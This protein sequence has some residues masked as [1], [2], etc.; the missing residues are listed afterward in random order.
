MLQK[1]LQQSQDL[2]FKN[3]FLIK[4]PKKHL[5]SAPKIE[6]I[7][8]QSNKLKEN[9]SI[10]NIYIELTNL[11]RKI[12]GQTGKLIFAQQSVDSFKIVKGDIIGIKTTLRKLNLNNFLEKIIFIV[13]VGEAAN[14]LPQGRGFFHPQG[15]IQ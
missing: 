3:D 4:F 5:N 9:T 7:T 1:R 2:Q 14:I 15:H 11:L 13:H 12:T 10:T 8:I 6:K